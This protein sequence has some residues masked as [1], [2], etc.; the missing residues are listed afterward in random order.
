MRAH[1]RQRD[2]VYFIINI[3]LYIFNISCLYCYQYY[4]YYYYNR[5]YTQRHLYKKRQD[6][7]TNVLTDDRIHILNS[8]SFVWNAKKDRQWQDK[9]RH[10][11]MEKVKDLWQDY[12][13]KLVEFKDSHGE[14]YIVI[15][16]LCLSL[17]LLLLIVSL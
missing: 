8:I 17:F 3:Y 11:K 6:G 7:Q 10:R 2:G 5:V 12:Y 1:H 9:D 16:L 13:D 14:E 4:Y 15:E